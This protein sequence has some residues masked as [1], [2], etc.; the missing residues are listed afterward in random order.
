MTLVGLAM[1][2][3]M[4]ELAAVFSP[5]AAV[6]AQIVG[7]LTYNILSTPFTVGSMILN[8]VMTGAGATV[9]ALVVNTSCI[10]LVR[11]P[12]GWFLSHLVWG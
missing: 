4:P 10:W 9:Y 7:Y 11:L 2:P 8:G 6:Q 12:L 3:W 5:D 1:W